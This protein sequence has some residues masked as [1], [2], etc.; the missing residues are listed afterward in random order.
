MI[1]PMAKLLRTTQPVLYE[2]QLALMREGIIKHPGGRGPGSGAR[3]TPDTATAL[4]IAYAGSDVVAGVSDRVTELASMRLPFKQKRCAVS[5]AA[6]F[7]EAVT[8]CLSS[9]YNAVKVNEMHTSRTGLYA[10]ISYVRGPKG[11]RAGLIT[12]FGRVQDTHLNSRIETIINGNVLSSIALL[13]TLR[14]EETQP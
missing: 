6:T 13:L 3:A 8:W 9:Y 10:S 1:P 2:R 11:G 4:L 7:G 5:G 14:S 12:D